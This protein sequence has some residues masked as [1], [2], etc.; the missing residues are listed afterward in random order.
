MSLA[1]GT[2]V[3]C[4]AGL[5]LFAACASPPPLRRVLDEADVRPAR[6]VSELARAGEGRVSARATARV[7]LSGVRGASFARQILVVERPA[8]LRIEV[9]GLV[10]Q[11]VAVLATDGDRYELYRAE[12]GRI[13]EGPVHE[14]VL[15]EV[16][17]VPLAPREAVSL[18][19]A[20]PPTPPEGARVRAFES[21]DG[22]GVE[23]EWLEAGRSL[24]LRFDAAG[25][26]LASGARDEDGRE[27]YHATYTDHRAT[28]G[29]PFPH[30]IE[31]RFPHAESAAEID[32]REVELNPEL[33]TGW[34]RLRPQGRV[35]SRPGGDAR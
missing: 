33:P 16:A 32:Y 21:V 19:L 35:S 34:F 23:L 2:S 12:T 20:V 25:R 6:F 13:E 24:A 4:G 18:L 1:R 8:R 11:R 27:V 7:S 28:A 9:L 15:L 22:G 3:A 30:R 5:L 29:E 14:A 26:L 31:V 17:G 10:G